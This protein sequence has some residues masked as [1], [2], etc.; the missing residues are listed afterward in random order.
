MVNFFELNKQTMF[1]DLPGYGFAQTSNAV[2]RHWDTLVRS[3][4]ERD[5]IRQVLFLMDCRRDLDS[6]DEQVLRL[7]KGKPVHFVLTKADKL[8]RGAIGNLKQRLGKTVF[9]RYEVELSGVTP[10][11]STKRLNI[12]AL[13]EICGIN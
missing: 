2:R 8:N 6:Q 11:S 5:N 9:D 3:Y 12:D 10:V 4:L 13:E 7:L 1:V